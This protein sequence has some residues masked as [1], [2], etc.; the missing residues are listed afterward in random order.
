MGSCV[1]YASDATPN[2]APGIRRYELAPNRVPTKG[3][4]C[5]RFA[6]SRGTLT[7]GTRSPRDRMR[8]ARRSWFEASAPAVWPPHDDDAD[9]PPVLVVEDVA[10][11][12]K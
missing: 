7:T 2:V 11:S 12:A 6:R 3:A 4:N 10:E 5:G 8:G 9:Q 1:R